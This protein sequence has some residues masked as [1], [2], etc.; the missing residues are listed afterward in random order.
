MSETKGKKKKP[1]FT[2]EETW[3]YCVEM[4]AWINEQPFRAGE[5]ISSC[6]VYSYKRE[7]LKDNNFDWTEIANEC[8]F[9]QKAA[10]E[11]GNDS[12]SNLCVYCPATEIDPSFNCHNSCYHWRLKPHKFYKKVL[13]LNKKRLKTGQA[14]PSRREGARK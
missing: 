5:E 7:W 3:E 4:W 10:E 11:A 6:D 13:E 12:Y 2:L 14:S 1:P 8:F 9:C